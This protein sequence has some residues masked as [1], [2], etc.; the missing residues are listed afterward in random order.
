[1]IF[2]IQK[3]SDDME[4]PC[5]K[6][7]LAEE[8]RTVKNDR[9]RDEKGRFVKRFEEKT[10]QFWAVKIEAV[11]GFVELYREVMHPL[12]ITNDNVIVIMDDL[13]N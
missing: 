12:I 3:S 10:V 8:V 9:I 4:K 7:F 13:D 2:K 5:K 6:A 1:M 11:E